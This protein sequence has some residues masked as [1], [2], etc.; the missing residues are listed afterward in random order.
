M[1]E[2]AHRKSFYR[3]DYLIEAKDCKKP[4]FLNQRNSSH[5]CPTSHYWAD[6]NG[7]RVS[8]DPAYTLVPQGF[9][10]PWFMAKSLFSVNDAYKAI[11]DGLEKVMLP[12]T[13][14]TEANMFVN[15]IEYKQLLKTFT[16]DGLS[17]LGPLGKAAS[18]YLQYNFAVAPLIG[19]IEVLMNLNSKLVKSIDKWNKTAG[20]VRYFHFKVGNKF[21]SNTIDH[22]VSGAT[23][24]LWQQ[25]S[26]E[27]HATIAIIGQ[28]IPYPSTIDR[29]RKLGLTK[30]LS[31]IWEEIPFS[32]ILDWFNDYNSFIES[33]ES[34]D[35]PCHFK[36]VD[37]CWTQKTKQN[38][39]FRDI[40][41]YQWRAKGGVDIEE[42]NFQRTMLSVE[43]L[44][45][46]DFMKSVGA[47]VPESHFGV[48]QALL[49]TALVITLNPRLGKM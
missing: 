17:L 7:S 47:W 27:A 40:T 1:H 46:R 33:I 48:K 24:T 3:A 25:A 37:A 49:T 18:L 14:K 31:A 13:D 11:S 23:G 43:L 41:A 19:D 29:L 16:V 12:F 4:Y 45:D 8:L 44:N 26:T 34:V 6:G 21:A 30:P 39:S 2:C 32:F 36:V 10:N 9:E 22:T 20:R 38:A 5:K 28:H 42:S 15:I 35:T